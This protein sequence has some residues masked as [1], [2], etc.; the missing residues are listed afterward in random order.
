[1]FTCSG[2]NMSSFVMVYVLNLEGKKLLVPQLT[3][4]ILYFFSKFLE[5]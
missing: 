3:Y 2:K 5:K 4:H 1:L